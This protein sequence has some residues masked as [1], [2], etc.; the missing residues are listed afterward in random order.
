MDK[1]IEKGNLI[2]LFGC[3]LPGMFMLLYVL[4]MVPVARTMFVTEKDSILSGIST[5]AIFVLASYA[6]GLVL[7][8][9]A[10]FLQ[11]ICPCVFNYY[12]SAINLFKKELNNEDLGL[13]AKYNFIKTNIIQYYIFPEDKD[14]EKIHNKFPNRIDYNRV[15]NHME[16]WLITHGYHDYVERKKAYCM[17]ARS[18][19]QIPLVFLLIYPILYFNMISFR[20]GAAALSF[21]EWVSSKRIFL[22]CTPWKW[23]LSAVFMVFAFKRAR[24]LAR[25]TVYEN[26]MTYLEALE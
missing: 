20:E 5:L 10:A 16:Y 18:M 6:A 3:L 7:M 14:R 26:V 25:L 1:T 24:R 21:C 8:E 22:G 17:M 13:L 23:V 2:D 12:G 15:Y 11:G 9:W 19:V 4:F